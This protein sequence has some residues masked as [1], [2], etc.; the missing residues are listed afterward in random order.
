MRIEN[1]VITTPTHRRGNREQRRVYHGYKIQGTNSLLKI[2]KLLAAQYDGKTLARRLLD[3]EE[4]RLANG[5]RKNA[6]VEKELVTKFRSR[7]A[8]AKTALS[9]GRA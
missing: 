9:N 3:G 6:I 2:G 4:I 1:L 8:N 5:E 7:L